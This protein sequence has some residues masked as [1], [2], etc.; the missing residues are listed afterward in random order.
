MVTKTY[1]FQDKIRLLQED[2]ESERE[3]RNRVCISFIVYT[4]TIKRDL[5]MYKRLE[6]H[7]NAQNLLTT[8]CFIQNCKLFS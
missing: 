4:N 7:I 6:K 3:L 8:F 2:L 1:H 5:L